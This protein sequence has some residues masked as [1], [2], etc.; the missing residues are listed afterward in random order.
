MTTVDWFA[1]GRYMRAVA[2]VANA[3]KVK[4]NMEGREVRRI[5]RSTGLKPLK[6]WKK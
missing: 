2:A 1:E 6:E 5:V 3:L 4:P